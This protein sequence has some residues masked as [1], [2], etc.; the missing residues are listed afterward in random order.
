MAEARTRVAIAT[1]AALAAAVVA[2][3]FVDMHPHFAFEGWPGFFA[4]VG[5]A[6]CAALVGIA[7]AAGRLLD[8]PPGEGD[9]R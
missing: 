4:I 9:G 3:M 1:G 6:G 8:S 7:A 2:G 5:L